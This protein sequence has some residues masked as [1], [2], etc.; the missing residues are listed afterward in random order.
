M[1]EGEEYFFVLMTPADPNSLVGVSNTTRLSAESAIPFNQ[2]TSGDK[3]RSDSFCKLSLGGL[4]WNY[5]MLTRNFAAL[6]PQLGTLEF[7]E[8]SLDGDR[9]YKAENS[10][11]VQA[12]I[13]I[14][15][16]EKVLPDESKKR[17]RV[18]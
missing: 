3:A 16:G 5:C 4:A 13:G 7:L 11:D 10:V 14:V 1:E 15:K 12:V 9:W 8:L 2:S 18:D 17:R 6:G